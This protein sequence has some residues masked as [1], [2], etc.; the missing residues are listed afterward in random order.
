MTDVLVPLIGRQADQ[1]REVASRIARSTKSDWSAEKRLTGTAF[2]FES[3]TAR[4]MFCAHCAQIN[5]PFSKLEPE[6]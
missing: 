5:I 3:P 2:G 1:L 4:T 6:S